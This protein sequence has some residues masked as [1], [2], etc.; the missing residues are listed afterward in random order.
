[1]RVSRQIHSEALACCH[2]CTSGSL[3][4]CRRVLLPAHSKGMAASC[5]CRTNVPCACPCCRVGQELMA[6]PGVSG[7]PHSLVVDRAGVIR[8]SGHPAD[9][10]FVSAV[11]QV[12][13][14]ELQALV[15]TLCVVDVFMSE[16]SSS[17]TLILSRRAAELIAY[18][19]MSNHPQACSC[20][21]SSHNSTLD[22]CPAPAQRL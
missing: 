10:A 13:C 20:Q 22:P 9:P 14:S 6:A 18:S 5:R 11:R 15:R 19:A 8:F 3:H 12:L 16:S 4:W 17:R 1:V 2:R 21:A 7:I